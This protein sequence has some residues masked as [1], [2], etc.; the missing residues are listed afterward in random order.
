[1]KVVWSDGL[2]VFSCYQRSCWWSFGTSLGT[3]LRLLKVCTDG[4]IYLSFLFERWKN[5]KLII[6]YKCRKQVQWPALSESH[7]SGRGV[8]GHLSVGGSCMMSRVT[9]AATVPINS[10]AI[11]CYWG[12]SY[13]CTLPQRQYLGKLL[14]LPP[15][16]YAAAISFRHKTNPVI[17]CKI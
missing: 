15:L 16:S 3:G 12:H 7:P 4:L 9:L 10:G 14:R 8:A 6:Q 17:S 5:T 1:M 13:F 2:R 11:S